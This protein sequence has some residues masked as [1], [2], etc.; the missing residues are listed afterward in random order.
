MKDKRRLYSFRWLAGLAVSI[1]LLFMLALGGIITLFYG[2][3]NQQ[4]VL[5]SESILKYSVN[6]EEEITSSIKEVFNSASF[7]SSLFELI[8]SRDISYSA[9]LSGLRQLEVYR[10]TTHFIDSIYI[11][12]CE[13]QTIYASSPNATEAVWTPESFYDKQASEIFR[14]YTEYENMQPIFRELP[15]SYPVLENVGLISFLRYNTLA[16]PD[17]SSVMMVNV[18]QDVFWEH[19]TLLAEEIDSQLILLGKSGELQHVNAAPNQPPISIPQSVTDYLL[20]ANAPEGSFVSELSGGK[21]IICYQSIFDGYYTLVSITRQNTLSG[22]LKTTHYTTWVV[23]FFLL[24]LILCVSCIAVFSKLNILYRSNQKKL[25]RAEKERREKSYENKR[26][27]IL[28]FLHAPGTNAKALE[29]LAREQ[30]YLDKDADARILILVLDYYTTQLTQQY[31]TNGDRALVKYSICN[32][33]EEILDGFGIRFTAYEA[34]AHCVAVLQPA[35]EEELLLERLDYL[36]KQLKELLHISVTVFVSSPAPVSRISADYENLC[37][38]L[39]Y[40]QLLGSGSIITSVMLDGR[41]MSDYTI[42]EEHLKTITK[43]ILE[44]HMDSALIHIKE[45]F[46]QMSQGSYKSF[47]ISLM[48]VIA[49]LDSALSKLRCNYLIEKT[50]FSGTLIYGLANLENL[51]DIYS[52]IAALLFQIKD[53]VLTVRGGRQQDTVEKIKEMI[54][55]NYGDHSFSVNTVADELGMSAAYIGRLFKKIT[56]TT[57]VEYVLEVR[58]EAARQLLGSTELPIEKIV[59]MVGYGDTPYFY[60]IFKKV[61][62]CTP[63]VYRTNSK[64]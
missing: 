52:S 61:N 24:F 30:L 60:K 13:N 21:N 38:A 17:E 28:N 50:H 59:S 51:Q 46:A 44:L 9:L 16:S 33:T 14:S 47:Q 63:S 12:N 5:F 41:E 22:L 6:A 18:R 53:A 64:K 45:M 25:E 49:V 23:L 19:M 57:F 36:Q 39:P 26:Q 54:E 8:N 10:Q 29:A 35:S 43:E 3:A 1:V 27:A 11:Y 62:G 37:N 31:E 56:G 32:I 58:M 15:V 42:P 48:Q 40:K 34:G 55:K 2:V 7:D 4:A 20:S